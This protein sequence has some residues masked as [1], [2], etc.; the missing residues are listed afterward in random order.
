MGSPHPF[1]QRCSLGVGRIYALTSVAWGQLLNRDL[2][3]KTWIYHIYI[4]VYIYICIY[5]YMSKGHG[6]WLLREKTV[7]ITGPK[8]VTGPAGGTRLSILAHPT[9][10]S[11]SNAVIPRKEI[12]GRLKLPVFAF[13][14][15]LPFWVPS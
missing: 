1:E 9:T 6:L 3:S 7:M 2:K 12:F 11:G 15:F 8:A 13:F 10:K 14:A 4:Y 5:I